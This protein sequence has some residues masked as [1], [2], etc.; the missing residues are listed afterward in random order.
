MTAE[1]KFRAVALMCAAAAACALPSPQLSPAGLARDVVIRRDRFGVPHITARTHEA[2]AFAFGYAQA[3]DHA[4]QI[5]RRLL[6]GRGEEAKYFGA[7]GIENDFAM[8]RLGSLAESRGGLDRVGQTFRRMLGAYAAGVNEYVRARRSLFPEGIPDFDAADVMAG[9]RATA[10]ES[11]GGP[12]VVRQLREKYEG[13]SPAEPRAVLDEAAGSNALALAGSRTTT[14]KPIL[15]GNPHLNWSSLYWE[16]Q[17]TVPAQM[18]FYGSTL[19]GM[20]VLRAG[21]NERLAFVQTNNAPDLDDIYRLPLDSRAPDHYLF[22]GKRYPLERRDVSIEVRNPAGERVRTT[23]TYWFS[24]LGPI[25]HRSATDA[26]A[27]RSVRLE[28][29]QY[30]EGFFQAAQATSL[31]GFLRVMR[32]RYVPTSNFTYADANGNILYLWNARLP[33]RAE[34]GSSY[35]LDVPASRK[36]LWRGLHELDDLPR[37]LNPRG[38]YVQNANNPPQFACLADPLD[39]RRYPSYVERGELGLRP[40]LAITMLEER[41]RFSIE[42]VIRLKFDTRVLLAERI[43]PALLD[44]LRRAT[45]LSAD[46]RAGMAALEEWDNRASAESRGAALFFRFWD[47]YIRDVKEP[48]ATRWD[49]AQP[50]ATPSGLSD[51]AAAIRHLEGAVRWMRD[52]Y[53]DERAAWGDI[54]RYRVGALDLPAEGC[55]GTYGCFRVQ[56]FV[57]V[58]GRRRNVAGNL[59]DRGPV[60]FGDA[61]VLVVD[62]STPTPTAWSVLAY[63]QTTDLASPHSRDQIQLLAGR[64]LRRAWFRPDEIRAN[65]ER[66]YRPIEREP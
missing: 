55:T 7:E 22:D 18:N 52:T 51:I 50:V 41:P 57:N 12:V 19:V 61:W 37:L 9:L 49:G 40:Q 10:V 26:F 16:A 54:N 63:G 20:P 31:D 1:L 36:Y 13:Q 32:R 46:A 2:A 34:D 43:K 14:G 48:F 3:E 53:G 45:A 65:L 17:V 27:L 44:A 38:G 23:R 21:F 39:M 59:A 29:W 64:R 30:F 8:A 11:V 47:T 25:V 33:R 5:V 58:E 60:G 56:R 6:A 24:H 4:P 66:E 28:A 15:L 42:D 35:E 62:F